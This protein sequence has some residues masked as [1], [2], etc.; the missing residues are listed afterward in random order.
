MAVKVA[1]MNFGSEGRSATGLDTH[2]VCHWHGQSQRYTGGDSLLTAMA[3]G[4]LPQGVVYREELTRRGRRVIAY[5]FD[6]VREG[7]LETMWVLDNPVVSQIVAQCGLP[8]IVGP[9]LGSQSL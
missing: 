7:Q 2:R 1:L 3:H 5:G 4:W 6:M 8:V 9:P